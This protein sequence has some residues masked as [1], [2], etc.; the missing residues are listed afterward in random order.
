[1][2]HT[3]SDDSQ[4]FWYSRFDPSTETWS[5]NYKVDQLSIT[6]DGPP[7]IVAYNGLM[8]I[9]GTTTSG[10]MWYATMTTGEVFSNAWAI[11]CPNNTQ[12]HTSANRP[13]AAVLNGKLYFTHNNGSSNRIVYGTFDGSSWSYVQHIPNGSAPDLIGYEAALASDQGVLHL[14]HVQYNSSSMPIEWTYFDGCNW[15]STEVALQSWTTSLPPSLAQGSVGL[16]MLT[17]TDDAWDPVWNILDGRQL[18]SYTWT[19]PHLVRPPV[20]PICNPVFG[21]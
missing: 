3:G 4:A 7:A 17:T 8:Y 5:G 2:V 6:S 21:Q 19:H 16:V 11:I 12:C 9:I 14:I 15:A 10:Q 13:A 20:A 1:M 18:Y